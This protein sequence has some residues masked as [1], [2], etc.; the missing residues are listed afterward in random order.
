MPILALLLAATPIPA[1][2]E[3][4]FGDWAVACDN[5]KR[6]EATA[7]LPEEWGGDEPPQVLLRRAAGP[8]GAITINIAP[9]GNYRGAATIAVDG[10]GV[11]DATVTANGVDVSGPGAE[12]L[13]RRMTAGR[14]LT[15]QS[16]R[17]KL[18]A[19]VSLAGLSATMRYVDAQQG[20]AGGITAIVARGPKAAV[21]VP[22]MA[23]L[24]QVPAVR[25]G[26][27]KPAAIGRM[28]LAALSKQGGCDE[29]PASP[30]LKPEALRLDAR[31][32]LVLI[33]CGSGAYNFSSAAFV[34]TDGRAAPARFD[35]PP[36]WGDGD[37][38]VPMLVNADWDPKAARLNSMAKGRGLGDC[39]GSET[40]VWD[41]TRFRMTEALNLDTCRGSINWLTVF[42]A[43]PVFR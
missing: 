36:T 6:C 19:T 20:R 16:A 13:A 15:V 41:G 11:L 4:I 21:A 8:G 40:W 42:R 30:G 27:G 28:M 35:T 24:P 9:A 38:K 18:L 34:V 29:E 33:P 25:P 26:A 17:G 2:P 31:S 37:A 43:Q 5:V 1:T 3:K 12:A 22:A 23:P 14:A 39:G 7:L 32:T 10:K